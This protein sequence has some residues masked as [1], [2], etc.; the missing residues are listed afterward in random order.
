MFVTIFFHTSLAC[1][2]LRDLTRDLLVLTWDLLNVVQNAVEDCHVQTL[3]NYEINVLHY[4]YKCAHLGLE[5]KDSGFTCD[6]QSY[7]L[8]PSL[9]PALLWD[10]IQLPQFAGS[11]SKSQC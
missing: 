7:D 3:V 9:P 1:L 5:C 6:L 8:V 2:D 4:G 10:L 11:G